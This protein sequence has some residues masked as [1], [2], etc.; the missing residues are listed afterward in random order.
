M[1]ITNLVVWLLISYIKWELYNPLPFLL[2]IGNL[3]NDGRFGLLCG[4]IVYN[5]CNYV[6]HYTY[7][8]P[9]KYS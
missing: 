2:D 5:I 9:T 1:W 3:S 6:A 8:N 4:I 7:L